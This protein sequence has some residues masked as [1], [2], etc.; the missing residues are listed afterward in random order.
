[1]APVTSRFRVVKELGRGGTS[2]VML[3]DDA[4][5]G[6]RV[7]VK[8]METADPATSLLFKREFRAIECLRHPNLVRLYELGQDDEGLFIV[9]EALEGTDLRTHCETCGPARAQACRLDRLGTCL[10]Q[11]L[12]ALAHL[13]DNG[14]VHRDLKPSNVFVT[15]TGRVKLLDFGVIAEL[16]GAEAEQRGPRIAGTLGFMAPEQILGKPV[17]PA[18]DLYALGA[19]IFE[20]VAGRPVFE[21][22]TVTMLSGHLR[23]D[24]P[25]LADVAPWAPSQLADVCARL[26]AKSPADRP[27][28]DEVRQVVAGALGCEAV[29][30]ETIPPRPPFRLFGRRTLR[31]ELQRCTAQAREGSF[32]C[33]TLLGPTGIG[34]S[35][36]ARWIAQEERSRGAVILRG[37]G[38]SNE[39]VAF[40]VLDAAVDD[41]AY[42][43]GQL[44]DAPDDALRHP[45]AL[46]S[47]AFPVLKPE[48]LIS[49]PEADRRTAF[50][51]VVDLMEHLARRTGML[52]LI[53][54]D[55]HWADDD[56]LALL[57]QV[58]ESAPSR[59][60]V[61]ATMRSDVGRTS[62]R[63]WLQGH[64]ELPCLQV[65]PL[66]PESLE[67]LVSQVA[68]PAG[69][70]LSERVIRDT[71]EVSGGV[72]IV[73]ELAGRGLGLS[74]SASSSLEDWVQESLTRAG[75]YAG[76]VMA[77]LLAAD[78][79]EPVPEL[80]QCSTAPASTVQDTVRELER[81]CLVRRVRSTD[82][83]ARVDVYHDAIRGALTTLLDE[84]ELARAHG[85]HAGRFTAAGRSAPERAVRHLLAAGRD[86]EAATHARQAARRASEQRAYGLAADMLAVALC[87]PA[88]DRMSLIRQR[89]E[90]LELA[91]RFRDAAL[92]WQE[93]AESTGGKPGTDARLREAHAW[94]SANEPERGRAC[95]ETALRDRRN[96]IVRSVTKAAAGLAFAVGPLGVRN[97]PRRD[98]AQP[99]R[100]GDQHEAERDVRLGALVAHFDPLAGVQMLR[101]AR[102]RHASRGAHEQ[103]AYCDYIFAFLALFGSFR[104]GPVPL[105]RRYRAAAHHRL[106]GAPARTPAVRLMPT[107]LDGVV[108]Q[109]AG[110]WNRAARCFDTVLENLRDHGL[111]G[112]Y[113]Y[114]RALFHRAHVCIT[115]QRLGDFE[116]CWQMWQAIAGSNADLAMRNN[117]TS[118]DMI[119]H[120]LQGRFDQARETIAHVR[121]LAPA[122]RLDLQQ[123]AAAF[124]GCLPD[125]Y[126]TDCREARRRI[127]GLIA[128][129]RRARAFR[130]MYAGGYASV[131]A[132]AEANAL[133]A[134][135][136]DALSLR[137]RMHA[138][139]A[140]GAP[141]M[142]CGLA[143]RALAYVA[144]AGGKPETALRRLRR[145]ESLALSLD[146]QIDV[147]IARYQRGLRL[148]GETGRE[149]CQQAAGLVEEQ[150]GGIA[151]LQEDVGLR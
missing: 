16:G 122:D 100:P 144:D 39:R 134:G 8:R 132:L 151:I 45:M 138:N 147:A 66:D 29:T 145:A 109:R 43:L 128:S 95:L 99:D 61:V 124:M 64:P 129:D 133:R 93:V 14:V 94:L 69:T 59:V 85:V 113:E 26:L 76:E 53:I 105:A 120:V 32:R 75:P 22:S 96:R 44:G 4:V 58:V 40:S 91:A 49:W 15:T 106:G 142:W 5:R 110:R 131:A 148:G 9:M 92:A 65:G 111:V 7:A 3:V 2:R 1:M 149:L 60:A 35:A 89:A 117:M 36:L 137:V 24:P 63:S 17:Q 62:A 108:H 72:P 21:G 112:S 126:V 115:H 42:A 101:Q 31:A 79:F 56:A 97:V 28:I 25:A 88:G 52:V 73:A 103:A 57:Q 86:R 104:A 150:G 11:V 119:R 130:M 54:D 67:A 127:A 46:A 38:R 125:L 10:A 19:I 68:A 84:A 140:R 121:V 98:A 87:H 82:G 83:V 18:A 135:D 81:A 139:F 51:A 123:Y 37:H 55:L 136:P 143:Q 78:G 47:R 80:L 116:R 48:D 74:G 77:W 102:A 114:Q 33:V 70:A 141:P 146:Q 13:H 50:N 6:Q 90:A 41:L 30:H 23:R 20:L 71:V 118:L 107:F 34:K 27:T 12:D